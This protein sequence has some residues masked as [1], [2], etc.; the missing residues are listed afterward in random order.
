MLWTPLL[1]TLHLPVK[2]MRFHQVARVDSLALFFLVRPLPQPPPAR[3]P[4]L[5]P[6]APGKEAEGRQPLKVW[7]Q[8][9]DLEMRLI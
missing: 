7:A 3:N 2:Q 8:D 1:R 9:S 5:V 4:V 6:G